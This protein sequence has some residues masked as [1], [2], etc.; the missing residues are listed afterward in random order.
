[1]YVALGDQV[2]AR[3][4]GTVTQDDLT[5]RIMA[6][7]DLNPNTP[8]GAM[9]NRWE[10]EGFATDTGTL[11]AVAIDALGKGS[12]TAKQMAAGAKQVGS[13]ATTACAVSG[14]GTAL[15]PVCGAVGA[16][17]GATLGAIAARSKKRT[18]ARM[19]LI[20]ATNEVWGV[21]MECLCIIAKTQKNMLGLTINMEQATV[22]L[23]QALIAMGE[24][25]IAGRIYHDSKFSG[26][27]S[28]CDDNHLNNPCWREVP[29]GTSS[30]RGAK[31][32]YIETWMLKAGYGKCFSQGDLI[33]AFQ[34]A[35]L[36]KACGTMD[37]CRTRIS[38]MKDV[39]FTIAKATARVI[40]TTTNIA[41]ERQAAIDAA[42]DAA[43]K[44]K[45]AEAARRV[46]EAAEAA[47]RKAEEERL[48]TEK[49]AVEK[50]HAIRLLGAAK[51]AADSVIKSRDMLLE[52]GLPPAE[53]KRHIVND[54]WRLAQVRECLVRKSVQDAKQELLACGFAAQ[55]VEQ[56]ILDVA[57][58]EDAMR[59]CRRSNTLRTVAG[60]GVFAALVAGA[61]GTYMLLRDGK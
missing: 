32:R 49:A 61:V 58:R 13:I 21:T 7:V 28:I 42:N 48:R 18:Q 55:E 15:T 38:R 37:T 47:R 43:Q 11:T 6:Q 17:L 51:L 36:K 44:A 29:S 2:A 24:T 19:D 40:A 30:P 31:A 52:C 50:A 33:K 4:Y 56:R 59:R 35:D 10:R 23:K 25:T 1:M 9:L 16:T 34:G 22:L 5:R 46:R 39:A 27:P 54:S 12:T 8:G 14:V 60:V 45:Q 57:W 20:H 41:H 3:T 53:V 26:G